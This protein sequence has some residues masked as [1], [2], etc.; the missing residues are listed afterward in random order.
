LFESKPRA[1]TS[2]HLPLLACKQK[3]EAMVLQSFAVPLM[4]SQESHGRWMRPCSQVAQ[5][6]QLSLLCLLF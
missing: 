6:F 2:I 1:V 3:W 4:R 5:F